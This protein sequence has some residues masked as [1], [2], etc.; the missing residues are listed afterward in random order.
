MRQH[1]AAEG[2]AMERI[3]EGVCKF[4]REVYAE[5]RALF[6]QLSHKQ[7]PEALF[8]T[9]SDSRIVPDLIT[10]S[11]PGDLFICR[12]AGNMVPPYGEVN[13]GVSATIEY[14]VAVLGVRHIIVA[15][16][17]DCGAMKGVLDPDSLRE[18]PTV[19]SWLGHGEVARRI[20]KD[21]HP[22]LT[23]EARM[24]MVTEE[25]VL[26]QLDHL[27]THPSV[28]SAMAR[29]QL[30]IHGWVYTIESGAVDA[31]DSTRERFVPIEEYSILAPGAMTRAVRRRGEAA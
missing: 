15:G 28:A 21:N 30:G 16:H 18:L 6:E 23:G 26:A 9:C 3:L 14:A 2:E 13:G 27:R 4:R 22:D 5:H 25:N 24:R 20:V 17:S 19:K 29:G 10:Q 31:W 8:I 1:Q 11:K 7:N 12:N